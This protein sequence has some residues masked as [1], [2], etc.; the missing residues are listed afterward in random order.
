MKNVIGGVLL[1]CFGECI[2]GVKC[3]VEYLLEVHAF[4]VMLSLTKNVNGG[5]LLHC[6]GEIR[7]WMCTLTWVWI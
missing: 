1:D 2:V 4:I 5:V 7:K 3:I 6:F